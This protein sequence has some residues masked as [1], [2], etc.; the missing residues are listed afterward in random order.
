[1]VETTHRPAEL[2]FIEWEQLSPEQQEVEVVAVVKVR[3]SD[4]RTRVTGPYDDR[5]RNQDTL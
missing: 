4:S 2:L 3:L 5:T 1:M